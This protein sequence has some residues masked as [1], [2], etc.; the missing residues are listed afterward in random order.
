MSADLA[1][2]G[3][4]RPTTRADLA[5]QLLARAQQLPA[6]LGTVPLATEVQLLKRDLSRDHDLLRASGETNFLSV[7]T[8]VEAALA[9]LTWK[10]YTP[11]VVDALREA[12]ASGTR[13]APL[14]FADYDAVRRLFAERGIPTVPAIDL[15]PLEPE[16]L[17]DGPK[18]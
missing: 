12:F 11:L 9:C 17:D 16:D 3:V 13:Q 1:H 2:P 18:G 5:R 14:T 4:E 8:L 15:G 7:V 6:L 10:Q